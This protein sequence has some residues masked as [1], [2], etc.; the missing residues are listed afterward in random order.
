MRIRTA[1]GLLSAIVLVAIVAL[2]VH[3]AERVQAVLRLQ[4]RLPGGV[5]MGSYREFGS[6]NPIRAAF[7]TDKLFLS[8]PSDDDLMELLKFPEMQGIGYR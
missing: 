6:E 8:S 2:C 7:G 1:L 4:D 5:S 3:R